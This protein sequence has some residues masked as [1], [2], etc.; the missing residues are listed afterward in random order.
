MEIVREF[1]VEAAHRLPDVPPGHK[2]ERLHG[3]SFRIEIAVR[4][5]VG[6][7]SGWVMDFA[8]IDEAF[9]PLFDCLDHHYM[10]EVEG[11]EN[12]TS[13]NLARWIWQRLETRLPGLERVVIR[14]T[15]TTA[16]V[17]RGPAASN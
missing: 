5:E 12:P 15:C 10:N 2:C 9:R 17:Y 6:A 4:G 11:L 7:K 8:E 1:T 13:E 14:E 3:H 16:C